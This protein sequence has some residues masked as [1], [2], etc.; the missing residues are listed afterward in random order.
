MKDFAFDT[1]VA[2]Q[3]P[4]A[5]LVR[6][7]EQAASLIR[8][9]LQSRFTMAGLTALLMLEGAIEWTECEEARLAFCRWASNE[10]LLLE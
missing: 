10:Q 6:T 5:L 3:A 2:V 1:P 4:M 8:T 7:A 9:H